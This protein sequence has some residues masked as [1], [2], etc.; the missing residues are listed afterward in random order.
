MASVSGI[1]TF[2]DLRLTHS[3]S[4]RQ[5]NFL[6]TPKTNKLKVKSCARISGPESSG[7][8]TT[9]RN[10]FQNFRLLKSVELDMFVTSDDEDE[11]SKGFLEEIEELERM[12]REPSNVLEGMNDKLLARELPVSFSV[13]FAGSEGLLVHVGGEWLQKAHRVDKEKIE[14]MC[15]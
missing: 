15:Q 4:S 8:I 12:T 7:C 3:S 10:M 13:L 5:Y 1:P 6:A 9:Q 11:M 14:L 2:N